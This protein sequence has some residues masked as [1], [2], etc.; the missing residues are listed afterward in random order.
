MLF[1]KNS[2]KK[3]KYRK[4]KI[5]PI[6]PVIAILEAIILIGVCTYAWF[7]LSSDKTIVS[8]MLEVVPNSDLDI[9]FAY[10]DDQF[11]DINK[12]IHNFTFEPASSIDGRNIYFPT[13]GT[14]EKTNTIASD[15]K[16]GMTFRE[17]T[18]NDI[19][20]KYI[21]IDFSLTNTGTTDIPVYL[22]SKSFFA[23]KDQQGNKQ[24]SSALRFAFYEN[25][26]S[27][28]D[29]HGTSTQN[30]TLVTFYFEDK[31][32]G[33]F[34]N[35]NTSDFSN[36]NYIPNHVYFYAWNKQGETTYKNA[37]WPGIQMK[38]IDPSELVG[39]RLAGHTNVYSYTFDSKLYDNFIFNDGK[40]EYGSSSVAH[41][42]QDIGNTHIHD[43]DLYTL[44]G[45]PFIDNSIGKYVYDWDHETF[46]P[47][48][49][50]D[51]PVIAPG[52]STG[53]KREYTP[54]V[55]IDNSS[56]NATEV[57]S[58]FAGSFDD[59][60]YK[61]SGESSSCLFTIPSGQKK[62]LSLIIWLEGTD[63]GCDNSY[64]GLDLDMD[65]IFVTSEHNTERMITYQFIDDTSSTW[66]Q[67][68]GTSRTG[69]TVAPVV[70]MYD[71]TDDKG[72]LMSYDSSSRTW[73]CKAPDYIAKNDLE[74]RRV[75]PSDETD[76]WNVWQCGS[77]AN[78]DGS[79][80]YG[81]SA[82]DTTVSYVA[83]ADSAPNSS[84]KNSQGQTPFASTNYAK[85]NGGLWSKTLHGNTHKLVVYDTY[86]RV[87]NTNNDG[88]AYL[89]LK[90]EYSTPGATQGTTDTQYVEYKFDGPYFDDNGKAAFYYAN[91][92]NTAVPCSANNNGISFTFKKYI[93]GD[94]SKSFNNATENSNLKF[95]TTFNTALSNKVGTAKGWFYQIGGSNTDPSSEHYLNNC[96]WGSD[97]L[98]I[99]NRNTIDGLDAGAWCQVEYL[100]S[101]AAID[102]SG[103]AY[104]YLYAAS[105]EF[106]GSQDTS[107]SSAYIS[108]VPCDKAYS[109][110][111]FERCNPNNHSTRLYYNPS[112]TPG[113]SY[114]ISINSSSNTYGSNK[115]YTNVLATDP[116]N[117]QTGMHCLKN[118][119]YYKR[120]FLKMK[121]D[122]STKSSIKMG[123]SHSKGS[124]NYITNSTQYT[125]ECID[126]SGGYERFTATFSTEFEWIQFD[127]YNESGS[128][129]WNKTH[130]LDSRAGTSC[131]RYVWENLGSGSVDYESNPG[132]SGYDPKERIGFEIFN[133]NNT[134]DGKWVNAQ[135][136]AY[137]ASPL[138]DVGS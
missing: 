120:I 89:S 53:F 131:D 12:Y 122:G 13:V 110:Y 69:N 50:G 9:D 35:N 54:V 93:G 56:G 111:V 4:F 103:N 45:S 117:E 64:A 68:T 36:N 126:R 118:T 107:I 40:D 99:Q 75:N 119:Y 55:N 138:I 91:V 31:F 44:K 27:V 109:R 48:V 25:D 102:A 112:R 77:V 87:S 24:S 132:I 135:S 105:D 108:V 29:I 32:P 60:L 81:F 16:R 17:G 137:L 30:N 116:S 6:I 42:T 62:F 74:F 5:S 10:P 106:K 90:Y 37:A 71:N 133:S 94:T 23:V 67:H 8:N 47:S 19:N 2:N 115:I 63:E 11:I 124:D 83:L 129:W 58:A 39:T 20:S 66:V 127:R 41:Q 70:Q 57:T 85:S 130:A 86:N 43:G 82:S 88:S 95:D 80:K 26:D 3:S 61:G 72:Y 78:S 123:V 21:C 79:F 96:Y 28:G 98:Y 128:Q 101:G 34:R 134:H 59:F 18:V 114:T 84:Y 125:M 136:T 15:N 46:H 49:S 22:S 104:S 52:V 73:S 65:F 76:V 38:H 14:F 33:N 121:Q 51:Y 100:P 92:P 113:G 7:A 1:K 97:I